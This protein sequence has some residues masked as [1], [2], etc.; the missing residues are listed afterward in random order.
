M[1][2]VEINTTRAYELLA[3][4]SITPDDQL[5]A[6]I[7][8]R[9]EDIGRSIEIAKTMRG[10]DEVVASEYLVDV[11]QRTQKL[12]VYMSDI[13][14]N[15]SV[16]LDIFVPI[17]FTEEE[18]KQQL[19]VVSAEVYRKQEIL[20]TV[21]E[22]L[23]PAVAEKIAYSLDVAANNIATIASSTETTRSLYLA[24]ESD[25]LLT[26]SLLLVKTDGI[27]I[28]VAVTGAGE[29]SV[30]ATTTTNSISP[31]EGTDEVME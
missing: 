13:D 3:S 30:N 2:R 20:K 16:A 17:V 15:R 12:V 21:K 31:D 14:G 6:D 11:L 27:D 9:L 29:T 22:K 23:S 8:R 19:A 5:R 18:Q 24:K 28:T 1:A 7:S 25:A 26:D 4:L 10:A